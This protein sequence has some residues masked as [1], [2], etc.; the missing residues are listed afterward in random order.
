MEYVFP[1]GG[2]SGESPEFE[3]GGANLENNKI[4]IDIPEGAGEFSPDFGCDSIPE[5]KIKYSPG[6]LHV[7]CGGV[8]KNCRRDW[9]HASVGDFDSP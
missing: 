4:K 2:A 3:V 6:A 9:R 7:V 5:L 8:F 1:L